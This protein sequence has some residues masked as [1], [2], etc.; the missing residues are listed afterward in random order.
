M[1][2]R[3]EKIDGKL[4][5]PGGGEGFQ[6]KEDG[7][8]VG[9]GPGPGVLGT[10]LDVRPI[11]LGIRLADDEKAVLLEVRIVAG[12]EGKLGIVLV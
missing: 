3:V 11:A 12:S 7:E 9:F 1:L 2:L 4:A 10:G 8:R 5:I 6:G